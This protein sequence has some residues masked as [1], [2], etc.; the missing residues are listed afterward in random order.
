MIKKFEH[1][2]IQ[3][4][5]INCNSLFLKKKYL[6]KLSDN[7]YC[8]KECRRIIQKQRTPRYE[9]MKCTVCNEEL[10]Y[11]EFGRRYQKEV[12]G[13]LTKGGRLDVNGNGRKYHCKSCDYKIIKEKHEKDPSARLYLLAKRR[14]K[15][16]NIGFNLTKE[17]VKK[18]W[19]EDNKICPILKKEYAFGKKNRNLN[20]SLDRIENNK[21]YIMGNV[22]LLSFKANAIKGDTLNPEIFKN[23]YNYMSESTSSNG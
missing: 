12:N 13:R 11:M 10:H 2:K 9:L 21:D 5:C 20:P 7:H 18:L 4:N 23:M 17:F 19:N 1:K 3:V 22:R 16:K 8:S 14:A 15:K 6:V